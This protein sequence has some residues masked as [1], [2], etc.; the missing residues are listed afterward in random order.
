MKLR[1]TLSA[2]ILFAAQYGFT[3]IEK[4]HFIEMD[5]KAWQESGESNGIK[6]YKREVANNPLI[7]LRGEGVIDAPIAKVA[8]VIF[9]NSRAT[10]WMDSLA[11]TRIVKKV[12]E[13]AQVEYDHISTPPIIMKDREFVTLASVH[14]D[15]KVK[16]IYI[17]LEPAD[18]SLVPTTGYVRGTL[19]GGFLLRPLENGQKTYLVTEMHGDPKGDVAKWIVNL[20]QA[21]W[22]RNTIERIREQVKKPSIIEHPKVVEVMQRGETIL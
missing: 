9:D 15:P 1:M 13:Y 17:T 11:E 4:P 21:G 7:A 20:F 3:A 18:D 12:S 22:A 10:E 6:S 2:I 14:Y 19:R 8:Q 16:T 5:V